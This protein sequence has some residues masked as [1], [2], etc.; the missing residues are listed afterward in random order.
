[1]NDKLLFVEL[2]VHN[3]LIQLT[4]EDANEEIEVDV[5]KTGNVE[6][7]PG[8]LIRYDFD[9][10]CNNSNVPL[11][12]FYWRDILPTD[13]VTLQEIHTGTWNEDLEYKVLYKTNLSQDYRVLAEGLHTNVD[14]LIDCKPAVVGLKSGEVITEFRFE[15]G[16][17]QPSF[18][19][20]TKPYIQCFV[21]PGLPNE[22]RFRNCTDVGGRRGD[23]WVIDKDC[24][25]T[26]I[27]ATPK[28]KLPKTG[29]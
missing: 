2:K 1:M 16:T 3:D 5:Q 12:E 8:D 19:P 18:A 7:M 4:V 25:V 21:N 14:N 9:G 27:Y 6:A 28:G 29:S 20:V 17:V 10:I 23:E 24:W 11:D 22:Y 15:F 13:A 26:I